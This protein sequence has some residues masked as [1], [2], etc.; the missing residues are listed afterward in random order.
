MSPDDPPTTAHDHHGIALRDVHAA[1]FALTARWRTQRTARGPLV[2]AFV[3]P[4]VMRKP[5]HGGE[6]PEGWTKCMIACHL[7]TELDGVWW[8]PSGIVD[9]VARFTGVA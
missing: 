3:A 9:H 6:P 7:L 5:T 2:L 8:I 1:A 4:L